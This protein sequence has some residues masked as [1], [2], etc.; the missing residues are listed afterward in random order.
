MSTKMATVWFPHIWTLGLTL[1]TGACLGQLL[2]KDATLRQAPRWVGTRTRVS[3]HE[4]GV[5]SCCASYKS[6]SSA[7]SG[8]QYPVGSVQIAWDF[9][10]FKLPSRRV[11]VLRARLL[12]V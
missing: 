7:L 11:R 9:R 1:S 3:D 6:K 4:C 8:S 2:A 12:K 10:L 5:G